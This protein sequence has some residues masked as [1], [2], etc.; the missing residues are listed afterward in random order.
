MYVWALRT[1]GLLGAVCRCE[2][3]ERAQRERVGQ[4]GLVVLLGWIVQNDFSLKI[5]APN[6]DFRT[7][8]TARIV[9]IQRGVGAGF[10][11]KFSCLPTWAVADE[12]G[13]MANRN[14]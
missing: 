14:P 5:S 2:A 11:G 6:F 9:Y 7:R 10:C 13:L 12:G 1:A 8:M 3:L 4:G